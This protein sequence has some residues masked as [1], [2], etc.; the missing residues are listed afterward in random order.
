[1]SLAK[2][3]YSKCRAKLS[4]LL[5]G[6]TMFLRF[7]LAKALGIKQTVA[8]CLGSKTFELFA[9]DGVH[10]LEYSRDNIPANTLALCDSNTALTS[11]PVEFVD[12][13]VGAYVIQAT[14]PETTRW[15]DWTKYKTAAFWTMKPW[16]KSELVATM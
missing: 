14:S 5:A 3:Y 4:G 11:P 13:S 15:R 16:L 6:K 12:S 8:F 10:T 7:A 2:A 1:M 9:E